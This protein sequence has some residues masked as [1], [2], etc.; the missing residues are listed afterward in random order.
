MTENEQHIKTDKRLA[1]IEKQ[2]IDV[3]TKTDVADIVRETM[4]DVLFTA[5]KGTKTVL[6]TAATIIGALAVIGGG[7]KWILALVGFHY[8]K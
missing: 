4:I 2:L 8:L 6:L 5:G 1:S 3:P 7:L